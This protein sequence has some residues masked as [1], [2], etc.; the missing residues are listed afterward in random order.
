MPNKTHLS[1]NLSAN[2]P[3]S[4]WLKQKVIL[5]KQAAMHLHRLSISMCS[6]TFDADRIAQKKLNSQARF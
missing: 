6:F 5:E 1:Q 4:H 3:F 2:C